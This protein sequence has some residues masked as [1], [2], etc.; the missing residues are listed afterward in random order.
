M[1]YIIRKFNHTLLG[2]LPGAVSLPFDEAFDVP[3]E[4]TPLGSLKMTNPAAISLVR[5]RGK[6]LIAVCGHR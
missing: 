2:T 6:S 5:A 3:T 4:K 1:L